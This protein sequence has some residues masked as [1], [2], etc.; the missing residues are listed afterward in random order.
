M[1]GTVLGTTDSDMNKGDKGP[2]L[3]EPT[4]CEGDDK[5]MNP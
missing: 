1:L 2:A 3:I 4:L 5:Q